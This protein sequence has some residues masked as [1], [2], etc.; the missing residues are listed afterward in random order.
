MHADLSASKAFEQ[1]VA[2]YLPSHTISRTDSTTDL[3]FFIPGLYIE[4]KEKRQ[5]LTKRWC[6]LDG[7][8]ERDLFVLDELSLRKALV[9]APYSYFVLRDVPGGLRLFLASAMEVAVVRKERRNRIGKGKLILAL[10]EFRQ[11]ESL[12]DIVPVITDDIASLR[13]KDSACWSAREVPQ[14]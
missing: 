7:V 12:A 8:E 2:G 14:V 13:W 6:L 11:M 1:E 9:H 10:N 5:A 4:V 3:D